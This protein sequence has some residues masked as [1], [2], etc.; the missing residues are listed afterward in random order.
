MP[1]L[2]KNKI[3]LAGGRTP[4]FELGLSRIY[5]KNPAITR[6]HHAIR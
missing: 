5:S 6:K 1:V 2:W 4:A 3:A